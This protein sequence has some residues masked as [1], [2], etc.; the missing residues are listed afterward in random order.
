MLPRYSSLYRIKMGGFYFLG[1]LCENLSWNNPDEDCT[2]TIV[3]LIDC[4]I[5]KFSSIS[6]YK[7]I[8]AIYKAIRYFKYTY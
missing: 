6:I 4:H 2:N 5:F 7:A 1:A 3:R 8:R